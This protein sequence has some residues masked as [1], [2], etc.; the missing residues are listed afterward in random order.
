MLFNKQARH[1][2]KRKKKIQEMADKIQGSPE[3]DI[4]TP[5]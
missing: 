5:D 1:K 4:Q 2:G 3:D